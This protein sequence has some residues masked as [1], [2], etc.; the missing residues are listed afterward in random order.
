VLATEKLVE[1]NVTLQADLEDK[2]SEQG[3]LEDEVSDKERQIN[4]LEAEINAANEQLKELGDIETLIPQIQRIKSEIAQLED[5][6]EKDEAKL[7]GLKQVSKDTQ[8]VIDVKIGETDRI[9]E[10]KSQLRLSTAINT[11]YSNWGFVTLKGG[12]IQ[13]VVPDSTLDV[14]RDGDVIAKLKVTTVEPNRAAAD[15]IR[16]S[17]KAD[18]FLRSGDKVVAEIDIAVTTEPLI[19][20][21]R[22]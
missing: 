20:T 5:D 9:A 18:H 22:K 7:A 16:E 3:K 1:E 6:I 2:A 17:V 10:G 13:G 14:V 21:T 8:S 11:V 15:I 12:D 4:D 19:D